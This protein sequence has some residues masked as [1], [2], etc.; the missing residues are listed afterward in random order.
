[1]FANLDE[2]NAVSHNPVR[3][4]KRPKAEGNEGKIPA[5]GD[6]QAQA[7]RKALSENTLKCNRGR[8]IL[9][10]FHHGLRCEKLCGLRVRDLQSRQ[11][12]PHLRVLDKSSR[13]RY[14]SAYPLDFE[15]IDYHLQA[16]G[17]S[18]DSDRPLLQPLKTRR[19]KGTPIGRSPTGR[20]TIACCEGMPRPPGWIRRAS[21]R[22][23]GAETTAAFTDRDRNSW[24]RTSRLTASFRTDWTV[25]SVSASSALI[26]ST[27]GNATL[28]ATVSAIAAASA[29]ILGAAW[30]QAVCF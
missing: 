29:S 8:A 12:V 23:P 16:A 19:G 9:A 26:S 22:T 10:T 2:A 17:V 27:S 4:V 28:L 3:G 5:L 1:M 24:I 20:V 14:V 30:S 7:L 13:V 15:R 21:A 11:G 25:F 18:D 6:G